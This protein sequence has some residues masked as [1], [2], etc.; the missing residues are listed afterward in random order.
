M[1]PLR[2]PDHHHRPSLVDV[3][4]GKLDH[5]IAETDDEHEGDG[6]FLYRSADGDVYSCC[7]KHYG[8]TDDTVEHDIIEFIRKHD[9]FGL[10]THGNDWSAYYRRTGRELAFYGA[11]GK[12]RGIPLDAPGD[13]R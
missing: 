7:T 2:Q 9:P 8:R 6:V 1:D 4:L 5:L 13:G 12:R 10:V 11:D 3:C